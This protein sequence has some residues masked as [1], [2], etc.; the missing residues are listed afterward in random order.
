MPLQN[1]I[2]IGWD[3]REAA[4][5]AVAQSSC[6]RH[7]NIPIPI[8]GLVLSDLQRRGFT[9]VRSNIVRAPPIK[10]VMWDVVS[11]FAMATEFACAR[12]FVPLTR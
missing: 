4:A 7:L 2:F 6:R 8:Y 11:D 12:F 9:R 1:S 3:A 10:P 5:F